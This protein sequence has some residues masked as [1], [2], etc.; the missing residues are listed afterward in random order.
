M[1]LQEQ[2]DLEQDIKNFTNA[3]KIA[4]EINDLRTIGSVN[5]RMGL[6]SFNKQ[7]FKLALVK[8]EES[9]QISKQLRN[10]S[11]VADR[12]YRVGKSKEK[13][14]STE[15]AILSFKD[16][17]KIYKCLNMIGMIEKLQKKIDQV[18]QN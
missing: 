4:T 15:E 13:L 8:F 10:Q 5:A 16:A 2:G 3:L 7:D 11:L 9:L 1:I 6:I 18:G 17:L 14:E 12:L